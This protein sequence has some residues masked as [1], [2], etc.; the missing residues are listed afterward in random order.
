M[1]GYHVIWPAHVRQDVL[2]FIAQTLSGT[3]RETAELNQALAAIEDG[4]VRRPTVAGESRVGSLRVLVEGPVCVG[5][6]VDVATR[7]VTVA[8]A[9]YSRGKRL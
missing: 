1:N 8:F 7:R 3:G 2:R 5:Y 9:R 6:R 4:L